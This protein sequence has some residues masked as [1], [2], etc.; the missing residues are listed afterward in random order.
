MAEMPM[1]GA[2]GCDQLAKRL[3]RWQMRVLD[4][5][6]ALCVYRNVKSA[7]SFPNRPLRTELHSAASSTESAGT[8]GNHP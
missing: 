4:E 1:S 7:E 3:T 8:A 5:M 6:T 2:R